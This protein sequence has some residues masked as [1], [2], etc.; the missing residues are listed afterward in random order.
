MHLGMLF[1]IGRSSQREDLVGLL[2]E[3]HQRI[4]TFVG[5][6]AEVGRR[7]ELPDAEVDDACRRCERYFTEALP[8]HVEDEEQ[9]LLP[10]LGGFDD[11]LDRALAAMHSQHELHAPILQEML[12]ACR[13]VR[14]T[15]RDATLRERLRVSALSLAAEFEHHLAMEE[16]V[17]FPAARLLT[18]DAEAQA[19]HELRARRQRS[20]QVRGSW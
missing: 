15:P 12:A 2:L 1:S 13:D 17:I 8:L 18:P 19:I 7:S 16:A 14:A 10:R 20:P 9:S 6:A 11:E 3:C 5:L 4:R